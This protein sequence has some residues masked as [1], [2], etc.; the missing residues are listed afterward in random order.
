MRLNNLPTTPRESH[1][2]NSDI[3][4]AGSTP[5]VGQS[6]MVAHAD[7]AGDVPGIRDLCPSNS[8][9]LPTSPESMIAIIA[10]TG[11]ERHF[12][13]SGRSFQLSFA[14]ARW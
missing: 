7:A 6:R 8:Q 2:L 14:A 11:V 9:F 1:F 12:R 3:Q 4:T 5:V 10:T 13:K